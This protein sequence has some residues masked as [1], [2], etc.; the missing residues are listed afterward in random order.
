MFSFQELARV[1]RHF[2]RA[3]V[4]LPDVQIPPG[5]R[6]LPVL[7]DAFYSVSL[8]FFSKLFIDVQP[9]SASNKYFLNF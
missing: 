5:L 7:E 4:F 3:L 6:G 8:M 1:D 9:N 2:C